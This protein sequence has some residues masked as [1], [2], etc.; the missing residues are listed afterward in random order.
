MITDGTSNRHYLAVKSISGLLRGI[1]S[2]PNGDFHCLNCF[3]HTQQIGNL[4]NMKE[5]VKIMTF[6]I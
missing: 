4:E 2:N 5:Y 3:L 1:T 6:V